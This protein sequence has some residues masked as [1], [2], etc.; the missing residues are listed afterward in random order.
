MGGDGTLPPSGL[1]CRVTLRQV[2]TAAI[3]WVASRIESIN[4][5]EAIPSANTIVEPKMTVAT[6]TA[7]VLDELGDMGDDKDTS[8]P[9]TRCFQGA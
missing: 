2:N 7:G 8:T 3:L 4:S 6:C 1:R 5:E 9:M